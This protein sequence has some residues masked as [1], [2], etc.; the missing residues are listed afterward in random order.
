MTSPK[1]TATT[2]ARKALHAGYKAYKEWWC[3]TEDEAPD[4]GHYSRGFNDAVKA[5]RARVLPD[6]D[7][8]VEI[9]A[10]A[11]QKSMEGGDEEYHLVAR[12][13]YDALM[14]HQAANNTGKVES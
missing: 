7:V 13:A 14:Q 6:R 10:K 3:R 8:A 2:D 11:M 4:F 12:A 9:M 1:D 5:L